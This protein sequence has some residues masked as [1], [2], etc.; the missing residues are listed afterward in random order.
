[1]MLMKEA[2]QLEARRQMFRIVGTEAVQFLNE[3]AGKTLRACEFWTA[4]D[5][6]MADA[7]DGVKAKPL[8]E[9]FD[10]EFTGDAV[11]R[12]FDGQFL[13]CAIFTFDRDG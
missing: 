5:D 13:R 10:D 2:H 4:M 3:S 11:V 12:G 6:A 1:M 8:L 9:P 7:N